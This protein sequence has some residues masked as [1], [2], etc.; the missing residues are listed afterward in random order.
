[1]EL[2]IRD[3]LNIAPAYT[4]SQRMT[5]SGRYATPYTTARD[6]VLSRVLSL[7]YPH[8]RRRHRSQ[9]SATWSRTAGDRGVKF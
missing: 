1:M 9:T 5:A 6:V 3:A 4:R 7:M 2:R 8:G